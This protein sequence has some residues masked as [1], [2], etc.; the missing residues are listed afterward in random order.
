MSHSHLA[1]RHLIRQVDDYA[2]RRSGARKLPDWLTA[3]VQQ[4]ADLFEPF[5][6]VARPGFEC[7]READR[8]EISVFLGK[9]EAVG[10]RDDGAQTAVNF[11]FDV[12]GLM[13]L[14]GTLHTLRWNAFPDCGGCVDEMLDLSFLLAEGAVHGE[15]VS[16][17]IHAGPPDDAG[18]GLKQYDDGSVV[19]V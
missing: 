15:Q 18:P 14:F 3:F 7:R 17:Q 9:T 4:A 6:G 19:S 2:A 8:W 10:G 1:I 16:L 12:H 13:R 11:A 5:S